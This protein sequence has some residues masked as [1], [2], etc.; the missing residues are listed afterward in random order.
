MVCFENGDIYKGGWQRGNMEGEG[1]MI[2]TKSNYIYKG[3]FKNSEMTGKGVINLTL[4]NYHTFTTK[5][6]NL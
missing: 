2:S 3:Q 1:V 5:Q 4:F 6:R